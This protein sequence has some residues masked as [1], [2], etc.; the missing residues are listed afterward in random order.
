MP[1]YIIKFDGTEFGFLSNFYAS[2]MELERTGP[3]LTFSLSEA[4]PPPKIYSTVEHAFQVAKTLNDRDGELIRLTS[5]PGAAKR[6]GRSVNLREDWEEVKEEIMLFCLRK[7]F[8]NKE[9]KD[10]LLDT[11]DAILIEG[12]KW[13]DSEWGVCYC[14]RCNGVGKNKLGTLLMLVREELKNK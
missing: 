5:S 14:D 12:N 4:T 11:G 9:L 8:E 3:F 1:K 13:H 10:K 6:M 2:D 7:K